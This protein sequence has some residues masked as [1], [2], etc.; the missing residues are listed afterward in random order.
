MVNSA[1]ELG[2]KL[3]KQELTQAKRTVVR[4]KAIRNLQFNIPINKE[5]ENKGE[6]I[7]Q[8]FLFTGERNFGHVKLLCRKLFK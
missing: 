5:R 2:P 4:E 7:V 3:R 1:G 8:I 6:E